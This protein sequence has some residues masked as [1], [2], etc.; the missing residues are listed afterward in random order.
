MTEARA[1]WQLGREG[2]Q[3]V[4]R[5]SGDWRLDALNEALRAAELRAP[6]VDRVCLDAVDTADSATLAL[7][8]D[9]QDQALRRERPLVLT[10]LGAGLRELIHLYGLEALLDETRAAGDTPREH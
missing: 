8:L 6:A 3:T 7:L 10:G 5:L 1:R 2:E 4:L 9:W